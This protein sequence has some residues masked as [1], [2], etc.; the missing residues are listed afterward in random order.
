MFKKHGGNV[1]DYNQHLRDT[2]V[3]ETVI[4]TKSSMFSE[5]ISGHLK[6]F[7][8]LDLHEQFIILQRYCSTT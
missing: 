2:Q 6:R 3:N 7:N 8:N 4:R 5:T 1:L